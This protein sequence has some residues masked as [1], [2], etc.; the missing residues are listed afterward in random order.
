MTEYLKILNMRTGASAETVLNVTVASDRVS[1]Y[2]E[3][4]YNRS[5]LLGFVYSQQD[6]PRL[7]DAMEYGDEL[8]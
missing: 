4:I 2:S 1:R 5:E 8:L 6:S 3:E 7:I